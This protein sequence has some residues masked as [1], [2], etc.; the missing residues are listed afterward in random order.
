MTNI[1]AT[2]I[3][4]QCDENSNVH[5]QIHHGHIISLWWGFPLFFHPILR[6]YPSPPPLKFWTC[7]LAWSVTLVTCTCNMYYNHSN[8]WLCEINHQSQ[9]VTPVSM[10]YR[11]SNILIAM[12]CNSC[13][14]DIHFTIEHQFCQKLHRDHQW[15]PFSSEYF[16]ILLDLLTIRPQRDHGS[17]WNASETLLNWFAYVILYL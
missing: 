2:F 11:H 13:V 4:V 17:D 10:F 14:H 8:F 6:N 12:W 5:N 3:L 9:T 15:S 16:I 7:Q 1:L